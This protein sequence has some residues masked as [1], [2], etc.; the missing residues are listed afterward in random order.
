MK[1]FI[2]GGNRLFGRKH[3][4]RLLEAGDHVTLLNRGKQVDGLGA[5]QQLERLICDRTDEAKMTEILKGRTF[6]AVVDQVCYEAKDA[7]AA[8]RVFRDKTPLYLFTSTIS[9]YNG[10]KTGELKEEDYQPR[11]RKFE[12]VTLAQDYGEGKRQ[13]ETVFFDQGSFRVI[14]ARFPIVCGTDDP[15]GRLVFHI[16]RVRDGKK[17]QINNLNAKMTYFSSHEAA[18]ALHFLLGSGKEGPVNIGSANAISIAGLLGW[19]SNVVGKDPVVSTTDGD[20]SPYAPDADFYPSVEKLKT[21]GFNPSLLESWMPQL[22]T[23]LNM[24]SH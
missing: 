16:E 22:I 21:W 6:D 14:A 24:H 17:I 3:A 9:T 4:Q 13:C 7:R 20:P 23:R 15:T 18:H 8:C 5:H 2:I 10:I 19:I 11:G 12:D 1:V